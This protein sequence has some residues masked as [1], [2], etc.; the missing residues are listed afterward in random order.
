LADQP[1][2][3]SSPD[4]RTWTVTTARQRR[5]F[6]PDQQTPFFWA[7]VVATVIVVIVSILIFHADTGWIL[8]ILIPAVFLIWAVGI[9]ATTLRATISA[10][11]EGPPPEHRKWTV[12]KR[13]HRGRGVSGVVEAIRAGQY[14]TEPLGTRLDEI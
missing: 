9:V 11:T 3:V 13:F 1:L 12:L 10:E 2:K 4:G 14:S 5:S 8:Q 6:K 7:N